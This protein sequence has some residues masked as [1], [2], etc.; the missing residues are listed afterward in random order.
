CHADRLEFF[1]PGLVVGMG[2]A[3]SAISSGTFAGSSAKWARILSSNTSQP[4]SW[5]ISRS[6]ALASAYANLD[7]DTYLQ[8][9][10]NSTR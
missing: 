8:G 7:S 2:S 1:L 5:K 9:F 6:L 10:L 3:G 4:P